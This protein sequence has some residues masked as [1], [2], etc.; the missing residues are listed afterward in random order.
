[1]KRYKYRKHG[2]HMSKVVHA[3]VTGKN[4]LIL[5][6]PLNEILKSENVLDEVDI[7]IIRRK[8]KD[9]VEKVLGCFDF[10][11]ELFEKVSHVEMEQWLRD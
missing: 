6:T 5:P 3:K 10:D 8:S 11:D 7:V 9:L 1:M 4:T 2:E